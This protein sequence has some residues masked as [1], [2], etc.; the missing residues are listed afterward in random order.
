MRE[1]PTAQQPGPHDAGQAGGPAPQ[2]APPGPASGPRFFS[3]RGPLAR[4]PLALL[5]LSVLLAA[6]GAGLTVRAAQLRDG[7]AAANGALTDATATSQVIAAVSAGVSEIYSYSYTDLSAT[8]RAADR[9]LAGQAAAQYR[10]L[11]PELGQAVSERLTVTTRVKA[12]G[13]SSLAS[14][15]AQLL[16]FLDQTVTRGAG[17]SSTV[18]AQLDVT[19]RLSG[20][21]WRITNIES[22]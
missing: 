9:V 6:V 3:L 19:A 17:K 13:V 14:D 10:Q 22:R 4:G 21:T 8:Q 2:P 12:I 15:S 18:P 20:G 1:S 5:V 16:L 7:P 11:E